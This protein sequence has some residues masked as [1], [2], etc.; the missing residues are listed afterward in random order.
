MSDSVATRGERAAALLHGLGAEVPEGVAPAWADQVE[1]AGAAWARSGALW[2]TGTCMQPVLPAAPLPQFLEAALDALRL[3]GPGADLAGLDARLL[4]ERA[5]LAGLSPRGPRSCGGSARLLRAQGEWVAP[6]LPRDDDWRMVPAWLERPVQAHDWEGLARA[7]RE[8]GPLPARVRRGRELGLAIGWSD[9]DRPPR[10]GVIRSRRGRAASPVARPWVLD[11]TSLWAGPLCADLL[12]RCGARVTKVE[13]CS[14]PDGAR[15]GPAA[16]FDLLNAGTESVALDLR[17]AEG[18]SALRALVE[19]ADVVLESARPRALLQ[20]GIDAERW[21]AARPGRIWGSITGYGRGTP[22]ALRPPSSHAAEESSW[23]AFG[24]DAG[25]SGGLLAGPE[26]ARVFVGD[27]IADPV[28]GAY[29][30]AAILASLRAGGGELID[31]SLSDTVRAEVCRG[32]VERQRRIDPGADLAEP[33]ARKAARPAP[34]LGADTGRILAE[35]AGP[36]AH[37][38]RLSEESA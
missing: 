2:L 13:S 1:E 10:A 21:V 37:R 17:T 35:I 32:S 27:A 23:I 3:L 8:A 20:L 6:N 22:V 4:A 24:D 5:A 36:A 15:S 31:A 18:R 28:T 7:L 14:R 16:F 30:A 38:A 25:V 9:P 34:A 33:V 26:D 19:C 29:A 12:R 11:L